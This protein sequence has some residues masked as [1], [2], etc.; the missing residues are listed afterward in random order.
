MSL[1]TDIDISVLFLM[2]SKV[3]PSP[4]KPCS[5]QAAWLVPHNQRC[6][7]PHNKTFRGGGG[8]CLQ[9][10]YVGGDGGGPCSGS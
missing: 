8:P 6:R 9:C 4:T 2:E 3:S 1:D 7:Q 10:V 5:P